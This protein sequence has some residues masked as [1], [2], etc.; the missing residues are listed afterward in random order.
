MLLIKHILDRIKQGDNDAF[1]ELLEKHRLLIFKIINAQR[2]DAGDYHLDEE[3]LFQEGCLALY[4]AV[5]TYEEDRNVQF[6][7]YAY[8]VVAG[9]IR[10][11]V[12]NER[13]TLKGGYSSLD[14]NSDR[15]LLMCVAEDPCEYHKETQVLDVLEKFMATLNEEDRRIFQMKKDQY[16]YK[17]IADSLQIST[18]KVDNRLRYLRRQLRDMMREEG[19]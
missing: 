17:E 2:L 5:F 4:D 18:K 12:R 6:S 11:A 14:L 9:R 8:I 16:S 10:S 1:E 3:D 7:T 13:K 15:D 19:F